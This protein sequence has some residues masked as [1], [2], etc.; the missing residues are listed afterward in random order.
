MAGEGGF[1]NEAV[2]IERVVESAY[3]LDG[4]ALSGL[5]RKAVDEEH[6]PATVEHRGLTVGLRA[7]GRGF[8]Y[9]SGGQW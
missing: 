8:D 5:G 7:L 9:I 4:G 3:R 6:D 2:L 1:L